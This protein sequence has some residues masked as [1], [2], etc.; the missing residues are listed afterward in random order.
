MWSVLLIYFE[1]CIN[2][3]QQHVLIIVSVINMNINIKS[4]FLEQHY[5][6]SDGKHDNNNDRYIYLVASTLPKQ[7]LVVVGLVSILHG[8]VKPLWVAFF[9]SRE[10]RETR[11]LLLPH[12]PSIWQRAAKRRCPHAKT[13]WNSTRSRPPGA[14][15]WSDVEPQVSPVLGTTYLQFDWI[16]STTEL[17]F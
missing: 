6:L 5:T 17:R 13:W 3:P 14:R 16:V 2:F 11:L 8:R 9:F 4:R 10:L 12:M 7:T 15:A 1:G